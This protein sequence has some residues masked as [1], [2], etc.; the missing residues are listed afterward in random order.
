[1]AALQRWQD[2]FREE[3]RARLREAGIETHF[4]EDT[5]D[6]GER[7]DEDDAQVDSKSERI[8]ADAASARMDVGN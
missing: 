4:A 3:Q 5:E 1:M 8:V 2:R 6:D 7:E